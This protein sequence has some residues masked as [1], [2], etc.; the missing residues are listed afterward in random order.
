M[1]FPTSWTLPR[2]SGSRG[3]GSMSKR[4][5]ATL[6]ALCTLLAN[7]PTRCEE[8][9]YD[10]QRLLRAQLTTLALKIRAFADETG[11]LPDSL[12]Q[13]LRVSA[14]DRLPYVREDALIDPW[15]ELLY[16]RRVRAPMHFVVFSLGQDR[17]P[18]GT[19][20]SGDQHVTGGPRQ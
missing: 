19:G 13:L 7:A 10:K 18:G 20:N 1:R 12:S 17:V 14:D 9:A 2:C 4:L 5:P 3:V 8:L 6:L 15:G 16:F 11:Q